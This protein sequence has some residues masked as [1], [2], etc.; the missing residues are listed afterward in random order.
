[1]IFTGIGPH[2]SVKQGLRTLVLCSPLFWFRWKRGSSVAAVEHW[3]SNRYGKTVITVDSGRSA[4]L[5]ALQSLQL[6]KGDE[7]CVQAFTCAVVINAI[8]AAGVKAI[9]VDIDSTYGMNA[10]DLEKKISHKTKAIIVQHTFGIAADMTAIMR[11]AKPYKSTIIEDCAHTVSSSMN[12]S[13]L[14][15]IGD[16][17]I[18]SFGSDKAIS[19]GRG[20]AL[21]V[22]NSLA[23][24]IK[25]TVAVLPYLPNT[26]V[27][28]HLVSIVVFLLIKPI[29]SVG[30]K[31]VL[32][33]LKK[34]KVLH[35]FIEKSEKQGGLAVY[36]PAQFSNALAYILQRELTQI[37]TL[38]DHRKRIAAVYGK[39]LSQQIVEG[40]VLCRYPVLVD[41]RNDV[42][43]DI[44]TKGVLLGDWYSSPVGPI[45]I[46]MKNMNYVSG[47][48]PQAELYSAHVI[49][50]P[51]HKDITEKRAAHIFSLIKPYLHEV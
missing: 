1:M 7:V 32:G 42:L 30:G 28:K 22:S 36:A 11:I 24:D 38:A 13:L 40:T 8:H 2:V 47:A 31:Y 9:Y 51:T 15:T 25:K 23:D 27:A 35:R 49:N 3:L 6:K 33:V 20:G 41:N 44:K 29:Y 18:L 43:L 12:G 34:M 45:D 48:C 26:V 5:V 16:I 50:L 39:E 46:Q 14:G 17:G 19:C 10:N 4:L 37:D 21:I